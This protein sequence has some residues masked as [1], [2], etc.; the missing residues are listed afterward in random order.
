MLLIV[1]QVGQWPKNQISVEATP[2]VN[3]VNK[4]HTQ[5]YHKLLHRND[6][7]SHEQW[8]RVWCLTKFWQ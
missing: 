3:P 6:H 7:N 5:Q 2:I 4:Q 8:E 1:E